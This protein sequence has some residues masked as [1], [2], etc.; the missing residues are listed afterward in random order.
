MKILVFILFLIVAFAAVA[1]EEELYEEYIEHN[2]TA[3]LK[4]VYVIETKQKPKA[5]TPSE[6]NPK[7]SDEIS[8]E[9]HDYF[10]S[11]EVCDTF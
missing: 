10:S 9:I 5:P 11:Q 3:N 4:K 1:I 7:P 6:D 2:D 8:A